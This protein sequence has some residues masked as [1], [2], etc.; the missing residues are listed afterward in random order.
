MY[1]ERKDTQGIIRGRK[2]KDRQFNDQNGKGQT[3]IYKILHRKLKIER[4]EPHYQSRVNSNA[5]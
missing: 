5:P 4:H 1:I 3:L 2:S